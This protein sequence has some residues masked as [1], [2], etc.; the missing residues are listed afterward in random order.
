MKC[1]PWWENCDKCMC[2][3]IVTENYY[4]DL[5]GS[6]CIFDGQKVDDD[7]VTLSCN[8]QDLD[9]VEFREMQFRV[10]LQ[11]SMPVPSPS[12]SRHTP[13]YAPSR[14]PVRQ[15]TEAKLARSDGTGLDISASYYLPCIFT[16]YTI[17]TVTLL[18]TMYVLL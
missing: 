10:Y 13:S 14:S 1:I 15:L 8:P 7:R 17:I 11:T 6:P 2:G 16:S 5:N 4:P 3:K 18:V 9:T 12:Y